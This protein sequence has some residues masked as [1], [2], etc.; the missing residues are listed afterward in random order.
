MFQ[1]KVI[2]IEWNRNNLILKRG[3]SRILIEPE[4][5]QELRIQ[6]TEKSF[7]DCFLTKALANRE[8]RRVFKAWERKDDELLKKLYIEVKA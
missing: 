1:S 3:E 5:I 8:A 4:K 7:E 2:D 6:D